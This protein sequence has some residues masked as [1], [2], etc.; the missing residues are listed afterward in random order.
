[1]MIVMGTKGASGLKKIVIGSNA[2]AVVTKVK[3]T[4]LIVPEKAS[5][6]PLQ[7]IAL[8]TD[9]SLS[10]GIGTLEPLF[11]M[12]E[13]CNATL[14]ILH[15]GTQ[16]GDLTLDQQKNKEFLSDY[17]NQ[18]KHS[19]HFLTNKKIEEDVQC[20]VESRGVN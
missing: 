15:M 17:L 5:F 16:A 13:R 8:P 6:K 11:E 18:R 9:F 1:D 10:Y 19:F 4:T 20:F 2:G 3:C 7:E 12:L 14:R